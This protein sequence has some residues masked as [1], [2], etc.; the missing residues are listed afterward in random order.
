MP[1]IEETAAA[2]CCPC[3]VFPGGKLSPAPLPV[4]HK[5]AVPLCTG[6]GLR[7]EDTQ[8]STSELGAAAEKGK[9]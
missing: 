6:M 1:A 3:V 8:S 9:R 2:L 5:G 4:Q 7:P